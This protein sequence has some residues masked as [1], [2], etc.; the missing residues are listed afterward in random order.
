MGRIKYRTSSFRIKYMCVH[1]GLLNNNAINN[2]AII[3]I[4]YKKYNNN[5]RIKMFNTFGSM[6]IYW[7]KLVR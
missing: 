3:Y 6:V 7:K 2:N 4:Y 5:N 1:I